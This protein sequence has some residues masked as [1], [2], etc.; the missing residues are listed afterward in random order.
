MQASIMIVLNTLVGKTP[1]AEVNR[2]TEYKDNLY[3]WTVVGARVLA[4][5][6]P[7]TKLIT[8][9]MDNRNFAKEGE[10]Y[11]K[12]IWGQEWYDLQKRYASPNFSKEQDAAKK[13]VAKKLYKYERGITKKNLLTYLKDHMLIV[14][15]N[16]HVITHSPGTAGHFVVVYGV[17]GTDFLIHD[18]GLPPHEAWNVDQDLFMK[19]YRGDII[20]VPKN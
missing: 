20:V 4:E 6:I 17:S 13:L 8:S 2:L 7:G 5:K 1:F 15:I 16:P 19:A 14:L 12:T 9:G 3:S 18:P 10:A 11:L